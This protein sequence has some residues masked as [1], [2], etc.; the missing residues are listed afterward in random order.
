MRIEAEAFRDDGEAPAVRLRLDGL[1]DGA[2]AAV[3]GRQTLAL[4]LSVTEAIAARDAL[5]RALNDLGL[6]DQ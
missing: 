6:P 4:V 1:D 3:E 5:N 2:E